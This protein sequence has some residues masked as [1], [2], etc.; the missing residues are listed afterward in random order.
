M[1]K[2]CLN[3]SIIRDGDSQYHALN[4]RNALVSALILIYF[5]LRYLTLITIKAL[6]HNL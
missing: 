5:F 3:E 2:L 1:F 6:H 4:Y